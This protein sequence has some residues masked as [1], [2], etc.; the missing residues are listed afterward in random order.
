LAGV[1]LGSVTKAKAL[2]QSVSCRNNQRQLQV[3]WMMYAHEHDDVLPP[4]K[5]GNWNFDTVCP[6][7]FNNAIGSWV[8]GNATADANPWNIRNGALFPYNSSLDIYHCP[9]DKSKVDD[10][11]NLLRNRSYAM[12]Y[13]MNGDKML[14]DGSAN[15][16]ETFP[17]VKERLTQLNHAERL[18]VFID[19]AE[20]AIQDGIF[21]IHYPNDEGEQSAG[22]HWMDVPADRHGRGCNLTF[23]DGHVADLKWHCSKKNTF[24]DQ[25]VAGVADKE[26]LRT[27]QQF[28]P[29]YPL[30]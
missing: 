15:N 13:C 28:I 18:F 12:S 3:A 22:P 25:P 27:L 19:E 1:L 17:L 2:A 10:H 14:N 29:D 9:A 6:E 21:F 26:D 11:P 20:Q 8:L 4:N 24:V 7:G 30:R 5:L 16:S 23:A